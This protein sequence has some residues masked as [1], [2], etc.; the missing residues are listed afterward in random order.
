MALNNAQIFLHINNAQDN[1]SNQ[2]VWKSQLISLATENQRYVIIVNTALKNQ[3][4]PTT[5]INPKG[6][7]LREVVSLETQYFRLKINFDII[8]NW[9]IEQSRNDLISIQYDNKSR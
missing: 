3:N 8:S 7:V 6:E 1:I 5:V 9:Y 2:N 4:Y